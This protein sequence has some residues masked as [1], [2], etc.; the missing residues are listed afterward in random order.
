MT[1]GNTNIFEVYQFCV[2]SQLYVECHVYDTSDPLYLVCSIF[3]FH[4]PGCQ[5]ATVC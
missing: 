5:I 1:F 3:L 4:V 2:D